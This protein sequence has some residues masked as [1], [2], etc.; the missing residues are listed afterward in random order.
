[1]LWK[2]AAR[3]NYVLL[4]CYLTP[5]GEETLWGYYF[6]GKHE[7]M[8]FQRGRKSQ[9]PTVN[10]TPAQFP[11]KNEQNGFTGEKFE[12]LITVN[13]VFLGRYN[14]LE[15]LVQSMRVSPSNLL[16]TA[17][18]PAVIYLFL[19]RKLFSYSTY[20]VSCYTWRG[21]LPEFIYVRKRRR[22]KSNTYVVDH[23][24][25]ENEMQ[26]KYLT[27]QRIE[28]LFILKNVDNQFLTFWSKF[29][30]PRNHAYYIVLDPLVKNLYIIFG[31]S[32][33]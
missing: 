19:S 33:K 1:M 20:S 7:N 14:G 26:W 30:C 24:W 2:L 18:I 16:G 12:H 28:Y 32:F 29:K 15:K 23:Q 11:K 8:H 4:H 13:R 21:A 6:T 25:N 5:P 17:H 27:H 9:V 22:W 31:V 10:R 3:Q